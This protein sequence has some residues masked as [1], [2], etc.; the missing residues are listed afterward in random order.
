MLS[1]TYGN[2]EYIYWKMKYN[3]KYHVKW[4]RTRLDKLSWSWNPGWYRWHTVCD[5]FGT[6]RW[7]HSMEFKNHHRIGELVYVE[8]GWE[9]KCVKKL[10]RG[11]QLAFYTFRVSDSLVLT[12]RIWQWLPCERWTLNIVNF[13]NASDQVRI[14]STS[15]ALVSFCGALYVGCF[16]GASLLAI[17]NKL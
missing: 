3:L 17:V 2:I 1:Q 16:Q 6:G 9:W 14:V 10:T 13:D 12:S 11:F 7:V 4:T 15:L 5:P 8:S